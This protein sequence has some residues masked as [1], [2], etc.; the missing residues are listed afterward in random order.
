MNITAPAQAAAAVF[1]PNPPNRSIA[2]PA[3]NV[4]TGGDK[5]VIRQ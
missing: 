1:N 5:A 3:Q 2:S 4:A